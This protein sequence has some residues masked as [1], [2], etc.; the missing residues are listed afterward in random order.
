VLAL[1]RA[2]AM[3]AY[4]M[5]TAAERKLELPY[6]VED[7]IS[8][9]LPRSFDLA[10]CMLCS[11]TYILTDEDFVSHLR[12]VDA[13]LSPDGIYVLELPHPSEMS[14]SA[15][16]KNAWSMRDAGGNLDVEWTEDEGTFAPVARSKTCRV[17]LRYRPHQGSPILIEDESR[18]RGFTRSD[19]EAL[20]KASGCFRVEA[21]FGALDESVSLDSD[22]A[23]RMIIVLGR[24]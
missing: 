13:A 16:T 2:P 24:R 10:A 11:A 1:D 6:V 21:V 23:W 18:Q 4:A 9:E 14:G 8:F 7:M 20:V 3:A 17:R 12:C 5:Q 19:I 15:K 22:S